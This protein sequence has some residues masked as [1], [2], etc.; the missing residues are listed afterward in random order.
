M[1]KFLVSLLV[2]LLSLKSFSQIYWEQVSIPEIDNITDIAINASGDIFISN[3]YHDTIPLSYGSLHRST[4]NGNSWEEITLGNGT[5]QEILKIL[6]TP[7]NFIYLGTWGGGVW[8]STD[9]GSNWEAKNEGLSE[10]APVSLDYNSEGTIYA[11]QYWACCLDYSTDNGDNWEPTNFPENNTSFI[12]V[13]HDDIVYADSWNGLYYSVDDGLSWFENNDGLCNMETCNDIAI[14]SSGS[15]TYIG[16]IGAT[17]FSD[18]VGATWTKIWDIP[19]LLFLPTSGKGMI[20][21]TSTG[22]KV[23]DYNG[24][25]WE[26]YNN[27]LEHFTFRGMARDQEG[28]IWVA[29]TS[30]LYKSSA[31]ISVIQTHSTTA[32]LDI[33]IAPNP[34][35]DKIT[36]TNVSIG[37]NIAISNMQGKE[38][39]KSTATQAIETINLSGLKRGIYFVSI[40]NKNKEAVSIQKVLKLK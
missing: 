32:K 34:F 16:T 12:K 23:S 37:D 1:N 26:T 36:I 10:V 38:I 2:L 18:T 15:R 35:V 17:Y 28:Y 40:K 25:N 7:N 22:I 31:P 11:G 4:D 30:H 21:V 13:V 19:T 5:F 20:A 6:I 29:T 39:H 3:V 24:E 14:G 27:G 33:S 8:R 9:N